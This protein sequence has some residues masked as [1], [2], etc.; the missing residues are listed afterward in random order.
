MNNALPASRRPLVLGVCLAPVFVA[1]S[2]QARRRTTFLVV[3]VIRATT[4]LSV[5]FER[6]VRRVLIAPS[7]AEARAYRDANENDALLAGES[8]GVAPVGFDFGNSPAEF[9]HAQ[10][11]DREIVFATTNGTHALRACVGGRAVYAAALRNARAVCA[12]ALHNASQPALLESRWQAGETGSASEAALAEREPDIIIVCSGRGD[13]PAFDDT[14]CAGYLTQ[15]LLQQAAARGTALELDEGARIALASASE[16]VA[17]GDARGALAISDAARATV[18]VGLSGDLDWCAAIDA[19]DVVA[20]VAGT[21][22]EGLLVMERL[23]TI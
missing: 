22:P 15:E 8:D 3:D 13:R 12:A 1:S 23:A 2:L 11:T 5:M 16:V 14:I 9:E 4:T 17:T 21:T 20:A 6:G 18:R 10:V 7:I 19:T